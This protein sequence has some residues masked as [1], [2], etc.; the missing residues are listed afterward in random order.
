[1]LEKVYAERQILE[2]A[3][4]PYIVKL[5]FAF[6]TETKLYLVMDYLNGGELFSYIKREKKFDEHRAKIYAAELVEAI[7][8]LHKHNIIYRDLKPENVLFDSKGHVRLTDFGLS[9]H[10]MSSSHL[11][12]SFCGTIDYLAPEIVSGNGYSVKV[13]WWSWGTLLYQMLSGRPPHFSNNKDK[14][15]RDIVTRDVIIKPEFSPQA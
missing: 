4:N 11:T 10:G 12:S 1:M 3:D 5:H 8:Y 13:D 9:K 2:R 15:L 6:Q 7:S 14:M